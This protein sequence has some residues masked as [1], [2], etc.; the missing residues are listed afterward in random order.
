VRATVDAGLLLAQ[1]PDEAGRSWLVIGDSHAV[2][3][4]DGWMPSRR[5]ARASSSATVLYLGPRLLRS[6]AVEGFPTWVLRLVR[7]RRRSPAARGAVDAI[8]VLGEIDLR[9]HLAKPGRS[10]D[11]QLEEL[12]RAYV[13]RMVDLVA[14][15]GSGGRVVICGPNPPSP[16]YD[17]THESY[18]V[19]GDVAE[20][21]EILDRLVAAVARQVEAS[22]TP[23][24]RFLDVRP[25][26]Q[27][28][29]GTLSPELTFDGCHLNRRGSAAVR[30]ALHHLGRG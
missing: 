22:G 26:V 11:D 3:L 8:V 6:V 9:C 10:G 1:R 7:A 30:A 17:E 27:A 28:P 5:V 21:I 15:L 19:V 18:P 20:R 29:D 4:M 2:L 23:Q 25:L 24:V 14:E 12:A 16:A 13:A